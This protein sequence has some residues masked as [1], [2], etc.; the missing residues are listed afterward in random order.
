M[1]SNIINL[2]KKFVLLISVLI[3]SLS[4]FTACEKKTVRKSK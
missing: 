2:S 1:V 4:L 3:F